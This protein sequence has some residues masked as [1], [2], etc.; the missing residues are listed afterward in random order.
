MLA[1]GWNT[2][3]PPEAVRRRLADIDPAVSPSVVDLSL[4]LAKTFDEDDP[5][6][7]AAQGAPDLPARRVDG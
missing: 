5:A 7:L 2:D 3:V 6:D 1:L 4:W